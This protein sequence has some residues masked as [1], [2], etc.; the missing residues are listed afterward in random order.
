MEV[1]KCTRIGKGFE[2]IHQI[3]WLVRLEGWRCISLQSLWFGGIPHVHHP[4]ASIKHQ[5]Q[6]TPPSIKRPSLFHATC[7]SKNSSISITQ[8]S[9]QFSLILI[10]AKAIDWHFRIIVFNRFV[11]FLL[12]MNGWKESEDASIWRRRKSPVPKM[13][14]YRFSE[15]VV[16]GWNFSLV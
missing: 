2:A 3:E 4:R 5:Y 13:V 6:L 16:R 1:C 15:K 8:P 14:I 7:L 10:F 11:S 9:F 12:K